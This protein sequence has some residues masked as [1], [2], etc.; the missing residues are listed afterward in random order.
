MSTVQRRRRL[1]CHTRTEAIGTNYGVF[2]IPAVDASHRRAH[3]AR[4]LAEIMED[5]NNGLIFH[6][7]STAPVAHH[8][9]LFS[10]L[11][12]TLPADPL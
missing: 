3:A 2:E 9:H 12:L 7:Q 5:F 10:R 8:T 11:D 1:F 4:H 6:Q